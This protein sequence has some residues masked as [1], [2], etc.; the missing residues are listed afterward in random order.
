MDVIS[1]EGK[2]GWRGGEN[3]GVKRGRV[4][5]A[6]GGRGVGATTHTAA[7]E[8]VAVPASSELQ[9][10]QDDGSLA[11]RA[12]AVGSS[13]ELP[14]P[15]MAESLFSPLQRQTDMYCV[16]AIGCN[17]RRSIIWFLALVR[18]IG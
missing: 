13:Q 11:P 12:R 3:F 7:S 9:C 10:C 16:M 6:T 17:G 8:R 14:R 5:A 1:G 2:A 18:R 4:V 15:S